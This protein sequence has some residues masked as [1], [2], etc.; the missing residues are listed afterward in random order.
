V[1][2]WPVGRWPAGAEEGT[3]LLM[4]CRLRAL[5]GEEYSQKIFRFFAVSGNL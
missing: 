1:P 2:A 4:P 3:L 5:S